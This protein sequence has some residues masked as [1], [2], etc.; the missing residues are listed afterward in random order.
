MWSQLCQEEASWKQPW[1]SFKSGI[2]LL[3]AAVFSWKL[4]KPRTCSLHHHLMLTAFFPQCVSWGP[5]IHKNATCSVWIG[6]TFRV[7]F[8]QR[9]RCVKAWNWQLMRQPGTTLILY[10]FT[11]QWQKQD[12][13]LCICWTFRYDTKHEYKAVASERLGRSE[14]YQEQYVF[15]YRW[16]KLCFYLCALNV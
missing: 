4:D 12:P 15:V 14:T 9:V 6:F 5:V 2:K 11:M 13:I 8:M 16:A 3:P 7:V 1:C 10:L